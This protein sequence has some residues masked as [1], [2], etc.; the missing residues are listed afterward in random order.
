MAFNGR[1]IFKFPLGACLLATAYLL[2]PVGIAL[3]RLGSHYPGGLLANVLATG[4]LAACV[5]LVGGGINYFSAWAARLATLAVLHGCFL[6]RVADT[7]LR[8]FHGRG[9]TRAFFYHFEWGALRI[10]N[11]EYPW[12]LPGLLLAMAVFSWCWIRIWGRLGR[13]TPQQVMGVGSLVL[14]TALGTVLLPSPWSYLP[15]FRFFKELQAYYWTPRVAT[16]SAAERG[17]LEQ[18]GIQLIEHRSNAIEAR[19]PP[20]PLNLITIYLE[21]VNFV[22]TERGGSPFPGLTPHLDRLMADHTALENHLGT[23]GFTVAGLM[24]SMCG[25]S[26]LLNKGNDSLI[27]ENGRYAELP[28]LS[29]ILRRAGYHQVYLG[30]ADKAFAGKA[31]FLKFH[32]YDEIF[33]W[34]EWIH[35]PVYRETHSPWGIHDHDLF[36]EALIT[37]RRL[38]RKPPFHL[39]ILTLNTHLPGYHSD[40]CPPYGAAHHADPFLD[41]LYCTDRA[42]GRFMDQLGQG[43]FLDNTVVAIVGDHPV[44]N[45]PQIRALLPDRAE[46]PRIVGIIIDPGGRLPSSIPYATATFDLAPTLLELLAVR[47]NA[48]FIQGVSIFRERAQR[49]NYLARDF[50]VHQGQVQPAD[51]A[52]G[53]GDANS[54]L[55][56]Q[57]PPAACQQARA[58][59]LMDAYAAQFH[60]C[61]VT[62]LCA[63]LGGGELRASGKSPDTAIILGNGDE[64][65]NFARG[66]LRFDF[67]DRQGLVMLA[68][69]AAGTVQERRFFE[70]CG[71]GRA[72][73]RLQGLLDQLTD[74]QALVLATRGRSLGCLGPELRDSLAQFG[75]AL[76]AAAWENGSLA[77]VGRRGASPGQALL[78]FDTRGQPLKLKISPGGCRTLFASVHP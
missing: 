46:D 28:C 64:M 43:G 58:M 66:G 19:R 60:R 5:L 3:H 32:G 63:M 13:F 41:G 49:Q 36:A 76:P 44:F 61:K 55:T 73:S 70:L 2:L 20:E 6:A 67:K 9:F 48:N 38:A 37:V 27:A 17:I 35:D 30:G 26:P 42:L 56:G 57:W 21:S 31:D 15:A 68:V 29:D 10:A 45:N 8:D 59:E 1:M 24:S 40:Q 47:H 78:A 53:C 77:F 33:G 25:V 65:E 50:Y 34:Q 11:Q 22:F 23:E 74:R 39:T 72:Q 54:G 12:V 69:D 16:Y 52:A 18:Y 75:L 14:L 4:A 7:G 62:T 71:E 51:G